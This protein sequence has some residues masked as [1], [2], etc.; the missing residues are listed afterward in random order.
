[1]P[2]YIEIVRSDGSSQHYKVEGDQVTLGR[3][4]QAGITVLGVDDLEPEHLMVAPRGD[5]VWVAMAKNVRIRAL[6]NNAPFDQGLLNY[7]SEIQIGQLR[8]RVLDRPP[9]PG[10]A[11]AQ[12]TKK[13]SSTP[14]QKTSPI[15]LLGI[16]A[17]LAI[18]WF[19]FFRPEEA[20]PEDL[21]MPNAPQLFAGPAVCNSQ[22]NAPREHAF[23]L[24]ERA[25]AKRERYVFAVQ[26]GIKSVAMYDEARAC[27][28]AIGAGYE[29]QQMEDRRK[30]IAD[31]I[32]E[33]YRIRRVRLSR[34]LDPMR[35]DYVEARRDVAS[36][37]LYTAHLTTPQGDRHEYRVW[38]ELI[39]RRLDVAIAEAIAAAEA[40]E[41]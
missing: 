9:R 15:V 39:E 25:A 4:A 20:G 17:I 24:A 31:K 35:P 3:S 5:Q 26:D 12:Q 18:G 13:V 16:P 30:R 2:T 38:L 8:L 11:R 7:G 29:A 34:S 37:R 33:D 10:A 36:L 32:D 22:G 14:D 23:E 40:A 1:M 19:V 21:T 28:T 6:M 27:F 41:E